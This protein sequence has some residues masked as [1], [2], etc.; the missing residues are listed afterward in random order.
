MEH[1][2]KFTKHAPKKNVLLQMIQAKYIEQLTFHIFFFLQIGT[3]RTLVGLEE[4]SKNTRQNFFYES[5]HDHLVK[6]YNIIKYI[7]HERAFQE[8]ET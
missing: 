7:S 4:N 2:N 3:G 6:I 5:N 8:M 1:F